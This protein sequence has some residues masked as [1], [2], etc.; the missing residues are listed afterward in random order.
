M[1]HFCSQIDFLCIL[2]VPLFM[3][4]FGIAL[5]RPPVLILRIWGSF[6]G[7]F[8]GHFEHFSAD[9]ANLEKC[10]SFKRNTCFG[11]C[12]ASGFTLFLLTFCMCFSCCFLDGLFVRFWRIRAS[13]G[14][15]FGSR[16]SQILQILFALHEQNYRNILQS[17]LRFTNKIFLN[18]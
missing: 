16:F 9:A 7:A 5:G 6:Q 3:L 8:R 18:F 1:G 14:S 11:R 15:P 4:I 10:N 12:W 17:W 2:F 13:K